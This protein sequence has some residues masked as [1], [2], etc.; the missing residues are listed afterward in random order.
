MRSVRSAAVVVF[1]GL[2]VLLSPPAAGAAGPIKLV[3]DQGAAFSLLGHS[4]G[5]IQ[6]QVYVTGFGPSPGG[7]PE[8]DV[9]MSTRCGGSGRGGGYKTIE[10]KGV[11]SVVWNWFGERRSFARLEGPA[12]GGPEFSAEDPHGDR[13]YNVGTSAY[14]ETGEPPLQPPAAPTGLQAT[15]SSFETAEEEPPTLRF[16]VSWTPDPANAGA[17]TS[18]TVTATPIGARA[19]PSSRQRSAARPAPRSSSRSRAKPPT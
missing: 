19:S 13:V 11:A 18:S 10:Y 3:L 16:T 2:M 1:A 17:I 6:E 7:Y 9:Y 8:G 4:C 12:G 15:L 14:L 5:G